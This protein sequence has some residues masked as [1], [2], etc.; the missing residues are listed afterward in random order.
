[1][2]LLWNC[3]A[4][5]H[6]LLL[7]SL[8][9]SVWCWWRRHLEL[10]WATDLNLSAGWTKAGWGW[11]MFRNVCKGNRV[12]KVYAENRPQT[13]T[14]TTENSIPRGG[15]WWWWWWWNDADP[16]APQWDSNLWDSPPKRLIL[17]HKPQPPFRRQNQLF[18][19]TR[20]PICL[21]KQSQLQLG[22]PSFRIIWTAPNKT[23]HHF[24]ETFVRITEATSCS[25]VF[26]QNI[27]EL[28]IQCL[29]WKWQYVTRKGVGNNFH[30]EQQKQNAK[31]SWRPNLYHYHGAILNRKSE[32]RSSQ[33]QALTIHNQLRLGQVHNRWLCCNACETVN[34]Y[35]SYLAPLLRVCLA[36]AVTVHSPSW[37]KQISSS[38][39][40]V[41][42]TLQ[43]TT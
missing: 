1:M 4:M 17:S 13:P 9:I 28:C 35:R 41:L 30:P 42:P 40:C 25:L 11:N 20:P 31:C 23:R 2:K 18:G 15:G 43:A 29:S 32:H 22:R 27:V 37:S 7:R 5:L 8:H 34:S 33:A 10:S 38:S 3:C 36:L 21:L 12:H 14:L 6:L 16:R 39:S 26:P 24:S 19:Q